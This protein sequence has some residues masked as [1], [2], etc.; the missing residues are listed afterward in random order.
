MAVQEQHK[1][2]LTIEEAAHWLGIGRTLAYKLASEGTLP[3]IRLSSRCVRVP[4]PELEEFVRAHTRR[5]ND[6]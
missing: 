4:L 5:E 3:T 6:L 2:L 1:M